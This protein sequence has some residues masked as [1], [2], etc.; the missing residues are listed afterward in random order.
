MSGPYDGPYPNTS[1]VEI[2]IEGSDKPGTK[3]STGHAATFVN[4]FGY[5]LPQAPINNL[6]GSTYLLLL[7][8]VTIWG[9]LQSKYRYMAPKI[10]RTAH[11][12][13]SYGCGDAANT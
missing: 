10:M 13:Q 5:T 1:Q 3:I 8:S 11:G 12:Y 4:G 6:K 7:L 9:V 2:T